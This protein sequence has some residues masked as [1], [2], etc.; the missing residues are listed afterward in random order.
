[1]LKELFD[2]AALGAAGLAFLLISA[3]V[4]RV[5]APAARRRGGVWYLE[6]LM[7]CCGPATML[8][9]ALYPEDGSM[10]GPFPAVNRGLTLLATAVSIIGV[11]ANLKAP[12][13]H[14][15]GAIAAL[16][17][18]YLTLILSALG[19]VIP[20]LPEAYLTTPL[21]LIAVLTSSHASYGWFVRTSLYALRSIILLS[22]IF[23]IAFPPL[24]FNTEESRTVFG[25]NRLEG[26][27]HHPNVL[28]MLAALAILLEVSQRSR[29]I[30]QLL[31][32]A[33][34]VV[35]QSTTGYIAAATGFVVLRAAS[36]AFVRRAAIV[37]VIAALAAAILAPSVM[38]RFVESLIPDKAVDF[39]GRTGIWDA[40]MQG[41]LVSP[42]WGYGPTLL[43]ETYRE[44]YLPGFDAAAQAHNQVVQTLAGSGVVGLIA[45]LILTAVLAQYS[46]QIGKADGRLALAA[47]VA[48]L[49]IGVTETPLRPAGASSV[50]LLVIII[51]GL[52]VIG[53]SHFFE[54]LAPQRGQRFPITTRRSDS[55]SRD[56]KAPPR[57]R[58]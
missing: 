6:F 51:V 12:R 23:A 8:V 33:T 36:S 53:R 19:G 2:I 58:T 34:L 24:A 46:F 52:S 16:V 29:L 41:W 43:D 30:W 26:I 17:L 27:S 31:A 28:A 37:T 5:W 25:L 47:L 50:T 22:I 45:L 7:F 18:F 39:T 15:A 3:L 21:L 57:P 42:V 13:R 40:A 38:S 14:I 55:L 32:L 49:V 48:L 11:I 44:M 4:I 54:S 56:S 9:I 10:G 20:A 1:M 35:A